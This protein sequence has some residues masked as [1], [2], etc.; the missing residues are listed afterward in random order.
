MR[1]K[2]ARRRGLEGLEGQG[3]SFWL[4]G[5]V[6]PGATWFHACARAD[7][8]RWEALLLGQTLGAAAQGEGEQGKD[9]T[10]LPRWRGPDLTSHSG[11]GS[12][13]AA[14]RSQV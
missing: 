11:Q 6:G 7:S 5:C 2:S 3:L 14:V 10:P 9:S 12:A 8:G 13:G 1:P 4:G